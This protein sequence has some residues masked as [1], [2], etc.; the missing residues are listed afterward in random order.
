MRARLRR[1]ARLAEGNVVSIPQ[2]DG[3]I[4]RFPESDLAAAFVSLTARMRTGGGEDASPEHPLLEAV[5]NS[6]DPRWSGSFYSTDDVD[7]E[8]TEDLSG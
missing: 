1:L 3:T 6:S 8:P 7:G 5:R 2:R 4:R